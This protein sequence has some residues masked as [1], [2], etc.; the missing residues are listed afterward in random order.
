MLLQRTL[1]DVQRQRDAEAATS[2]VG[3]PDQ[4]S[5]SS[6][7]EAAALRAQIEALEQ[8]RQE[9]HA[10]AD[11]LLQSQQALMQEK[12]KVQQEKNA[13]ERD[14]AMLLERLAF[15]Q[16]AAD[17]AYDSGAPGGGGGGYG[18][19]EEDYP[20]ITPDAA[21]LR[22]LQQ[23]E[24]LEGAVEVPPCGGADPVATQLVL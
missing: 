8:E 5:S 9:A 16:L 1:T 13:L 2:A 15:L 10:L 11:A 4:P 14:R 12:S 20:P 3:P 6:A 21:M 17:D 18:D 23:A 24:G 7:G 22:A 19:E